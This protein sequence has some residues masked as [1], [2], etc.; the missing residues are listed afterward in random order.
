MNYCIHKIV[1]IK[2]TNT[3]TKSMLYATN[4][5]ISER[6]FYKLYYNL[7]FNTKISPTT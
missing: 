4:Y 7:H 1:H 6:K 3:F 2:K 5:E